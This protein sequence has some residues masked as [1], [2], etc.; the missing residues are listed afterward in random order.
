MYVCTRSYKSQSLSLN[1]SNAV[2]CLLAIPLVDGRGG[3][4]FFFAFSFAASAAHGSKSGSLV[5]LVSVS[6]VDCNLGAYYF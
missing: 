5:T 3:A 1:L 2:D 6:L 4:T